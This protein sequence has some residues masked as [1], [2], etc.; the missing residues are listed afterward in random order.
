MA[1]ETSTEQPTNPCCA[2]NCSAAS[3]SIDRSLAVMGGE[4]SITATGDYW[5]TDDTS[6][7]VR[8]SLQ[9]HV[10]F[11]VKPSRLT[12]AG[13]LAEVRWRDARANLHPDT[14]VARRLSIE[15]FDGCLIR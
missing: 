7:G 9:A 10:L 12:G 1:R 3:S 6:A 8:H 14:R 13:P 4:N 15:R 11:Q 2:S 5:M